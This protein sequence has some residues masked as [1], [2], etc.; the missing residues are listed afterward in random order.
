[1]VSKGWSVRMYD[2]Q[3][4]VGIPFRDGGRTPEEGFD[5]WGL[6]RY[7]YQQRGVELPLYLIDP[8]DRDAVNAEM[9]M[10]AARCWQQVSPPAIGDVVLLE[11]AEGVP[12]HVGIYIGG[13]DFI[14]AYN[15][16]VVIDRL[17]NWRSRVVVFYKPKEGAYV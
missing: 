3:S 10:E 6:V 9:M 7:L 12:N 17:R 14:H 15:K 5:C 16:S 2:Y 8:Q 4:L 11:L 1:M 13:G